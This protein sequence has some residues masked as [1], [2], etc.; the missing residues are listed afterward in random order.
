MMNQKS[1]IQREIQPLVHWPKLSCIKCFL[2]FNYQFLTTSTVAIIAIT[3]FNIQAFMF[4]SA[5]KHTGADIIVAQKLHHNTTINSSGYSFMTWLCRF[6][7][8]SNLVLLMKFLL[9][10]FIIGEHWKGIPEQCTRQKAKCTQQ[11][12]EDPL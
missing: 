7:K 1:P 5:I 9:G 3:G 10:V 4:L 8:D 11:W 6:L 2:G 12:V